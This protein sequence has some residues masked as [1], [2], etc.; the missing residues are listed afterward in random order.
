MP[1]LR[2]VKKPEDSAQ[3]PDTES[4]AVELRS[5]G[6]TE[7]PELETVE[8]EKQP[9]KVAAPKEIETEDQPSE[10]VITLKKQIEDLKKAN[11]QA[12]STAADTEKRRKEALKLAED[13]AQE[14][15]QTTGRADQAEFDAVLNAIGAATSELESA[16]GAL[17]AAGE[18]GDWDKQADAQAR[19]AQAAGRLMQ[20]EDGK[21]ALESRQERQ[22]TEAKK[23]P[24]KTNLSVDEYID[25]MPNLLNSERTWMKAHPE[26][27]TDPRKNARL[28]AAYFDAEDA[29]HARG[30]D[31]YFQFIEERL[32][33][34]KAEAP[35]TEEDE[36]ESLEVEERKPMVSAPVSRETVSPST[37][38]TSST[39]VT[40]TPLQREAAKLAGIDELTY[41][42][43]VQKLADLKKDGHYTQN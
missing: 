26:L 30:S 25:S 22:K 18:A 12:L 34:R 40:L 1:R 14:L 41:A 23:E 19:I 29:K 37:G 33:Y 36:N 43:Q 2:V 10:E 38:K 17:R 11:E 13:R 16:K 21:A 42:R 35:K 31:A 5:E 20:L 39:R 8:A 9:K 15:T 7:V 24:V 6:E 4:V 32:G 27:M 3:I 28:Q